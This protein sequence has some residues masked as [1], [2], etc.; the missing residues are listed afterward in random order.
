MAFITTK[1][2]VNNRSIR[3]EDWTCSWED[4]GPRTFAHATFGR[5]LLCELTTACEY[6]N[7]VTKPDLNSSST[8]G[9]GISLRYVYLTLLNVSEIGERDNLCL[10]VRVG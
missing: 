6:Y 2:P 8:A 7:A 3:C 4:L 9:V 5:H 1:G 10:I